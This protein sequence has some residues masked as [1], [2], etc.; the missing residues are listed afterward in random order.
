MTG[1]KYLTYK[2]ILDF[3]FSIVLLIITLPIIILIS[4]IL[5]IQ[6][7]HF[8]IFKHKRIGKNGMLFDVYK[9]QTMMDNSEEIFK[10]IPKNLKRKYYE[11]YK[12]DNDPRVT[13]IG[14]IL[15]RLSLD[16]LP[17][18]INVLKGEMSLIGP[19]PVVKDELQKYKNNVNKLLTIRPGMTGL[20]QINGHTCLNYN[21]RIKLDMY[22][23]DNISL[24]LDISI[25]IKTFII[26]FKKR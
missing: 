15:R 23:I 25:F 16:E 7:K 6:F 1:I 26:I 18:L 9:F 13:K 2:R 17:Q 5:S 8:P 22:Y 20:W 12:L 3:L 21:Q 19:R 11:N 24:K 10:T 4:I 14:K